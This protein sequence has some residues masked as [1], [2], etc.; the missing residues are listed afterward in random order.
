MARRKRPIHPEA[1]RGLSELKHEIA[2]ELGYV[3]D[4]GP[5]EESLERT[6]DRMK[7]EVAGELGLLPKIGA[8]GWGE[9]TS[10]ECGRIG[11]LIGGRL[12]GQMVKRMVKYAE[13]SLAKADTR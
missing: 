5:P 4:G 9:M 7:Y 6:L 1:V 3:E 2:R 10:R 8:V 13:E 11:G 12:G